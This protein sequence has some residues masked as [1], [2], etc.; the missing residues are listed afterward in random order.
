MNLYSLGL[1]KVAL[2]TITDSDQLGTILLGKLVDE[3]F[4]IRPNQLMF[5]RVAALTRRTGNIPYWDDMLEDMTL[6]EDARVMFRRDDIQPV[7]SR[8]Q[9]TA[10]VD[11]LD[12]YRRARAMAKLSRHIGE[13]LKQSSVDLEE[14]TETA[15]ELISRGRMSQDLLRQSFTLGGAKFNEKFFLRTLSRT[16]D[17]Y[18]PTGF[19]NFD[20]VNRGIPR[21][22]CFVLAGSTGAGKSTIAL[23]IALRQARMGLRVS[24]TSLEM[25]T[26]ENALRVMAHVADR[27]MNNLIF[28]DRMDKQDKKSLIESVRKYHM[29]VRN[30]G[31]FFRVIAPEEDVGIEEI[32]LTQ[33][34]FGYDNY[35]IDYIGLLKGTDTEDMWRK[36][37]AVGRFA[38]RFGAMNN[39]V[40]SL[41]AQLSDEGKVRYSRAIQ[42]HAGNMWTFVY[43]TDSEDRD[44]HI[45]NVKQPKARNQKA[46]DFMLYE[47]FDKMRVTDL[48][49]EPGTQRPGTEVRKG[50]KGGRANPRG[51]SKDS[52]AEYQL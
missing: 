49:V 19:K 27:S 46:F 2:K 15:A 9:M 14:L 50:G 51:P 18:L 11:K 47:E 16:E 36:L 42:E 22:S 37:G 40:V 32:L 21:G 4:A 41:L 25:Q 26:E 48:T 43:G 35:F 38:K 45:I 24:L 3:H 20:G 7:K 31:G 23:N 6:P 33:K 29:Q 12:E 34:A 13:T 28:G 1:E 44:A 30:N 8:K 10:L 5:R 39:C 17:D 52:G